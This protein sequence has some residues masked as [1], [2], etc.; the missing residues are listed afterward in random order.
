M[1][2]NAAIVAHT[3]FGRINQADPHY[4]AQ[5]GWSENNTKVP[6]YLAIAPQSGGNSPTLE[7]NPADTSTR[8]SGNRAQ[9]SD[10]RI[11]ETP[12]WWSWL[13]L[14]TALLSTDA[15]FLAM[16]STNAAPNAAQTL[17]KNYHLHKKSL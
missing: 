17:Y 16:I 12:P 2:P 4:I 11:D 14:D 9:T 3:D 13:H 10:N 1:R 8:H 15:V 5:S 7:N 6:G